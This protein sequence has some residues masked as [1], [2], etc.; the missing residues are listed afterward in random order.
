MPAT[1]AGMTKEPA[2]MLDAS[3]LKTFRPMIATPAYGATVATNYVSSMIGFATA[4]QVKGLQ[5]SIVFKSDSL[6][7]RCRNIFVAE[8]MA[9][10]SFTHL[11][12]IDA[13]I[14]FSPD[15]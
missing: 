9:A 14:G 2:A 3:A 13:D 8:F 6:I 1:S 11:F 12:W 15:A 5:T 10:S 4:C 7:T